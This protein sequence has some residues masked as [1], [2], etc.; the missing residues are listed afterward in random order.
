MGL[1]A[2]GLMGKN[3]TPLTHSPINPFTK[4]LLLFIQRRLA[5]KFPQ[6]NMPIDIPMAAKKIKIAIDGPAAS[7]KSTT[8]R[9][10]ARRLDYLYIDSGAMYRAVTLAALEAGVPTTDETRVAELAGTLEITFGRNNEAT[11]IYLDG[12][13]VSAAIRAPRIVAHI[14]P[15]AANSRVRQ[16]LVAKQQSLGKSGGVVMDGRDITTV[17]FPDAELK[18]YMQA[19]AEE[20]ARRRVAE[21]SAKNIAA[22]FAEVL[23]SIEQRDRADL[24]RTHGPLKQAPD[25]I[26]IDTTA[27]TIAEQVEKIYRLARDIIERKD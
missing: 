10:V 7:G 19:S 21:L 3:R 6:K 26:V 11:E 5:Y 8:A 22:D 4:F 23:A 14:N 16:I 1:W 12:T 20:R 17:V 2:N 15:V 18:V 25:A 9:A 13:D 24:T 27:L